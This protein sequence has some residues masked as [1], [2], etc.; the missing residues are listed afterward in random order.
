MLSGG[1]HKDNASDIQANERVFLADFCDE[2]DVMDRVASTPHAGW[3]VVLTNPTLCDSLQLTH[4]RV[5]GFHVAGL[6][7]H[8]TIPRSISMCTAL[9]EVNVSSNNLHGPIPEAIGEIKGL[10]TFWANDNKLTGTIPA[11]LGECRVLAKL[12]L[13]ANELTGTIPEQLMSI[14]T[15]QFLDLFDNKLSNVEASHTLFKE[16][17]HWCQHNF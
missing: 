17:M 12:S 4:A 1:L 13:A 15:L 5:S 9:V 10:R 7:L 14:A 8:G 16:Q 3:P 6:G 11:R 2:T